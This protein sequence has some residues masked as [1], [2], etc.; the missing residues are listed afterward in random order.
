MNSS[1]ESELH[2]IINDLPR[3]GGGVYPPSLC[4]RTGP[5]CDRIVSTLLWTNPPV[6]RRAAQRRLGAK[7][8]LVIQ[9]IGSSAG[10]VGA[11]HR[12]N[13]LRHV[14]HSS[15]SKTMRQKWLQRAHDSETTKYSFIFNLRSSCSW[16]SLNSLSA[17]MFLGLNYKVLWMIYI[18]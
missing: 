14:K 18:F 3:R 11:N 4:C 16:G 17:F 10:R 12:L 13:K 1:I 8:Q 5:E 2:F 6:S 9:W 7:W 15:D